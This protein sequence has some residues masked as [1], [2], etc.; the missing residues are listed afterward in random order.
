MHNRKLAAILA[1]L[2]LSIACAQ[3]ASTPGDASSGDGIPVEVYGGYLI[4]AK[5]DVAGLKGLR[6]LVDTGASN[7][8]IDCN[9]ARRLGVVRHPAKLINFDKTLAPDRAELPEISFGAGHISNVSVL[10][11]DLGNLRP[12]GA[13][14]DGILG[15]DQLRRTNFVVDYAKKRMVFGAAEHDGMRS[16]PMRLDAQTLTVQAELDGQPV[17]MIADS[18][19]PGAVFYEDSLKNAL[20]NYRIEERITSLSLGGPLEIHRAFVPRFRFGGQDLDRE[21]VV[22]S[23]PGSKIPGDISGF[24]GLA[25]LSAREVEFDFDTHTLSWKR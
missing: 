10:I 17:R 12:A 24:L 18:G 7:T 1:T 2:F 14:L 5:V 22:L 6:F 3:A 19:A 15:L 25:S 9:V 21:V 11:E 4:V 16:V 23:T 13:R 20:A 8:A